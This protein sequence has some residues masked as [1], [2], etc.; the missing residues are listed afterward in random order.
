MSAQPA[1]VPAASSSSSNTNA[2]SSS[3]SGRRVGKYQLGKTLGSGTFGKVKYAID[4][5]SCRSVAIKMMDKAAIKQS[6]MSDQIKKEISIMKLIRHENVVQLIEV[7]ASQHTIYIVLELVTGGELFDLIIEHGKL[8][9]S[10]ARSYY[11]QLIDGLQH[12]HALGVAHRDLK[13]GAFN[14][15]IETMLICSRLACSVKIC[16]TS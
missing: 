11:R 14:K 9:E 1:A 4:T 3:S 10:A 2:S 15:F 12:C 6:Q 7:L 5:Q 16:T 13:P 8:S